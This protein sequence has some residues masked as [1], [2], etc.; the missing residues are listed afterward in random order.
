MPI[1]FSQSSSGKKRTTFLP[2]ALFCLLFGIVIIANPA[3]LAYLIA[4]FF[5]GLG[6]ILLSIWLK[7]R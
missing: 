7:M 1:I 6:I 3:I 4:W 5:I 2:S